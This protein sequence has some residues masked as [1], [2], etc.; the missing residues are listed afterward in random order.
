MK[1]PSRR[2]RTSGF[3]L[4][5]VLLVLTILVILAALAIPNLTRVFS[6]AQAK[7]AK[8]QISELEKMVEAYHFDIGTYPASLDAL[9]QPP[10]DV[11]GS[12]KWNGP[13]VKKQQNLLDPWE[14]P[15]QYACPGSH[16]QDFDIWTES[17]DGR[18]IGSW[19]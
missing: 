18:V 14:K 16:G 10:G 9:I 12:G 17:P 4:I 13:Y 15:I 7:A 19:D 2:R 8:T 11:G 6:G 3:T 5:E 1:T